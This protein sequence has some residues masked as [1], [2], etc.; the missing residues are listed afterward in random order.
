MSRRTNSSPKALT[1]VMR[2]SDLID[3]LFRLGVT[4]R[5]MFNKTGNW[6]IETL[7]N[8]HSSSEISDAEPGL[9]RIAAYWP[10]G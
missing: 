3:L 10:F 5:R 2:T 6:V 8:T 1:D 4:H 7:E 9:L